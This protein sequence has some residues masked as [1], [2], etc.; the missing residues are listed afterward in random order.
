[1]FDVIVVGAG[2]GGS[3]T[4]YR[5][6]QLG[7]EVCL[8]EK[9]TVPRYKPCGG[10]L[11]P[12]AMTLLSELGIDVDEH[13]EHEADRVKFLF[14]FEDPV[15]ADL[16]DAPVVMFNRADF[17]GALIQE[18]ISQGAEFREGVSVANVRSEANGCVVRTDDGNE[19]RGRFVI[20]ADG[21][22]SRVAQ[23]MDLN[24]DSFY[25]VALDAEVE[26]DRETYDREQQY[27]TFN[28][29]FVEQGYGWIFPKDQYLGM[30]V[31]GYSN[32]QSYPDLIR[33]YVNKSIPEARI[34]DMDI[35]GHPLPFFEEEQPVVKDRVGLVGDAANMVDSLSGEGIF[36]AMKAGRIAGESMKTT[37][38][39]G[40]QNLHEYQR[41]ISKTVVKEFKW[42]SRLASV[43]FRFPRKCYE[44]G[45]KRPEV[46]NLIKEVVQSEVSYDEIYGVIWK[47]IKN[48]LSPG[49]LKDLVFT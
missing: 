43:F 45:V 44:H 1:M 29:D 6:A 35:Y 33:E 11:P 42:S 24:R 14:N 2:P 4:A 20:G 22:G 41:R 5:S 49:T 37:L 15:V 12:H 36:Y 25:G 18:A 26:L 23:S 38:Q 8:L 9:E 34:S 3:I 48:R 7:L 32:D 13:I 27:A 31:G 47:K 39:E 16:S 17:D 46:V 19:I 40:R 21:A 10:G 28:I 30:G